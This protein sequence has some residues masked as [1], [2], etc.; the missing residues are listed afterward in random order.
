MVIEVE[1]V[2]GLV[3]LP[4]ESSIGNSSL[5]HRFDARISF[6]IHN[7]VRNPRFRNKLARVQVAKEVSSDG[8]FV[9]G[10]G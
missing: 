4:N 6:R 2:V 5:I 3:W 10:M 7:L 9:N 1:A 8:S